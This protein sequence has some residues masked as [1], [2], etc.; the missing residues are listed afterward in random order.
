MSRRE[1]SIVLLGA[2]GFTGRFVLQELLASSAGLAAPLAVAGRNGEKLRQLLLELGTT[3]QNNIKVP[4]GF[5]GSHLWA[6][7][8]SYLPAAAVF[9]QQVATCVVCST[10]SLL[11][12]VAGA[13]VLAGVDVSDQDSLK[14]MAAS[15]QLVIN[16][17]G[18]YRLVSAWR[19]AA[20]CCIPWRGC[21]AKPLETI[22]I[23][24]CM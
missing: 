24:V 15:T 8:A 6:V 13:Q 4:A 11:P 10:S 1:H 12:W 2:T 14:R 3:N 18:P 9:Q 7:Q 23:F 21:T 19:R 20:T 22:T 17:V 16:V 5:V